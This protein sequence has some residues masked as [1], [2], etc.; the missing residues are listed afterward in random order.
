M[1]NIQDWHLALVFTVLNI[2][3][4]FSRITHVI[5]LKCSIPVDFE[6]TLS[7]VQTHPAFSVDPMSGNTVLYHSVRS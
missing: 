2:M 5:P 1:Y 6:F 4:F 7:H 3:Y